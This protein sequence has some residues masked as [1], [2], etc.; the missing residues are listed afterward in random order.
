M[1]HDINFVFDI[2]LVNIILKT[3]HR[4]RS[5]EKFCSFWDKL[6]LDIT[7]GWGSPGK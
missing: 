4:K 3:L 1:L 6:E 5:S 7:A 2:E